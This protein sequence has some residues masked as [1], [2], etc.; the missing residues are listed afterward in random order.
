M[1]HMFVDEVNARTFFAF[2]FVCDAC[3]QLITEWAYAVVDTQ[4]SAQPQVLHT[5][6][7]MRRDPQHLRAFPEVW[8]ETVRRLHREWPS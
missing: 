1:I 2:T 7:A 8:R 5:A 6:C 3:R 4:D